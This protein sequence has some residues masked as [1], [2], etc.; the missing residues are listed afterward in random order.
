[1]DNYNGS[2]IVQVVLAV[3]IGSVLGFVFYNWV[4]TRIDPIDKSQEIQHVNSVPKIAKRKYIDVCQE[5][6]YLSITSSG[7]LGKIVI[8]QKYRWRCIRHLDK[9]AAPPFAFTKFPSF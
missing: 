6:G 4:K 7:R 9:Q 8:V 1:M 5:S 2:K 3:F